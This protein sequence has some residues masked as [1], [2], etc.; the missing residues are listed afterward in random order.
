VW[1]MKRQTTDYYLRVV[2]PLAF[3]LIVAYLSIFIPLSHFE[4][5][6]TIQ[7]TALLAAVALYL[8]LPKLD[9]DAATVSDRIFVFNYMAVSLMIVVSIL[10]V[11]RFVAARSWLAGALGLIHVAVIPLLFAAMAWYV[12]GLSMADR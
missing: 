10:R 6:A 3:I 1:L 4:A 11:N 7:V 9:T 12:H 5:I 2:V 8:S